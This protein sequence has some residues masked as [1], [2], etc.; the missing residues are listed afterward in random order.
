VTNLEKVGLE[1]LDSLDFKVFLKS[2]YVYIV[3]TVVVI[4]CLICSCIYINRKNRL[5][6]T[7]LTDQNS[8]INDQDAP[9]LEFIS[10][11]SPEDTIT[12]K[13]VSLDPHFDH[14]IPV[15]NPKK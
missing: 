8:K 12:P 10:P 4:C 7:A 14:E 6:H 11:A 1:A 9:S 15:K 13:A 5:Q 3:A 2:V